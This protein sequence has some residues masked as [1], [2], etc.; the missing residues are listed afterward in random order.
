MRVD[1]R[2]AK[3]S[4]VMSEKDGA[5]RPSTRWATRSSALPREHRP[6]HKISVISAARRSLHDLAA[7]R[8]QFLT[9][10]AELKDTMAMTLGGRAAE[11]I[12]SA[13]SRRRVERHREGHGYG[14][15][16][17]MRFGMSEKPARRLRTR[18]RPAVPGP[19]VQLRP[20]TPTTSPA[21]ST[22]RSGAWSRRP[23]R[24]AGHPHR[25]V[26]SSMV[27]SEIC[28]PARRSRRTSSIACSRARGGAV[29][30]PT[31]SPEKSTEPRRPAQPAASA[32]GL[33][34][35]MPAEP[36]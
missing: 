10:R 22:A 14:Q 16:M 34:S 6:G 13:R 9:T 28:W 32:A 18:P 33:D 8:G 25:A 1:R 30:G 2:P 31:R 15:Q 7:D 12:S 35:R 5:S 19:R 17:V 21:R 27:T 11:E 23:I 4:R 29:F 20:A 3:K 26:P 36:A 24:R